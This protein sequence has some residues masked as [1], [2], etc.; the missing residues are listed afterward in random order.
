MTIPVHCDYFADLRDILAAKLAADGFKVEPSADAET[1]LVRYLNVQQRRVDLR[2]RGVQ[3]SKELRAR[4]ASLP[5]NLRRALTNIEQSS[6]RGED[7]NPYL[8]RDV[9]GKKKNARRS[10]PQ[11]NDWGIKHMHLGEVY[12]EPGMIEGTHELLFGMVT[13]DALYFIEVGEHGDWADDRLFAILETNWPELLADAALPDVSRADDDGFVYL[14]PTE[15]QRLEL[16]KKGLTI[17]TIGPRG[18]AYAPVG[19]G[20][21]MNGLNFEVAQYADHIL[22]RLHQLQEAHKVQGAEIGAKLAQKTGSMPTELHLKL[23]SIDDD[24][25]V[26][27]VDAQTGIRFVSTMTVQ[28][29]R[30][31]L[32]VRELRP[33]IEGAGWRKVAQ[34]SWLCPD[35]VAQQ[36]QP[37][38]S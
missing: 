25:A 31:N 9:V 12:A 22:N 19:G 23:D 10:D 34:G 3:W 29:D 38:T 26:V 24:D 20:A 36:P 11:F 2:P 14:R 37:L 35:C 5:A 4:E 15:A 30:C 33:A 13:N 28:C 8:S 21:M 32:T 16:R 17:A 1:V 18:K 27:V 7:L 6:L